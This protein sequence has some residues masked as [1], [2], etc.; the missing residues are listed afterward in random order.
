M[1]LKH[2]NTKVF[3]TSSLHDGFPGTPSSSPRTASHDANPQTR[4]GLGG[5]LSYAAIA[6]RGTGAARTV[7]SAAV[8]RVAPPKAKTKEDIRVLVTVAEGASRPEP[9]QLRHKL[10]A[11]L[12]GSP[13]DIQHVRRTPGGYAIQPVT[14]LVRDRLVADDLKQELSRAFD[15]SKTFKT[16]PK[17]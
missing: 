12:K 1:V 6:S 5:N 13:S 4:D 17:P 16:W 14:K 2:L 15:A 7:A 11:M 8:A 3:D 9:F 10:V